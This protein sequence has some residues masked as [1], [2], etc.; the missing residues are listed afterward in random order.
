MSQP[1]RKNKK[2]LAGQ[3]P[4]LLLFADEWVTLG[5]HNKLYLPKNHAPFQEKAHSYLYD[6][7]NPNPSEACTPNHTS[8]FVHKHTSNH[9]PVCL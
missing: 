2:S 6:A 7:H 9:T 8:N 5:V 3:K 4:A 1:H